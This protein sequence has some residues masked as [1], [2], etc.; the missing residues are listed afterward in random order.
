M[1]MTIKVTTAGHSPCCH[2][3]YFKTTQFDSETC[4]GM[5]YTIKCFYHKKIDNLNENDS[6]VVGPEKLIPF[7][8]TTS[9]ISFLFQLLD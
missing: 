8:N 1:K 4:N 7:C 9:S 6:A 5:A 2:L 3:G